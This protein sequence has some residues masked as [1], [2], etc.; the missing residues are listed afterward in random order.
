M[1]RPCTATRPQPTLGLCHRPACLFLYT[2]PRVTMK[3]Q[4]PSAPVMCAS[5]S[6][7]PSQF[8]G[9]VLTYTLPL[10]N[11]TSHNFT[12]D[13]LLALNRANHGLLLMHASGATHCCLACPAIVCHQPGSI[14]IYLLTSPAAAVPVMPVVVESG[15]RREW[16]GNKGSRK[17]GGNRL[18]REQQAQLCAAY[19]R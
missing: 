19:M 12:H 8:A 18:E 6:P 11:I 3:R 7:S 13:L 17:Q 10:H 2:T 5:F 14:S 9:G 16:R 15:E 1:P 4:C